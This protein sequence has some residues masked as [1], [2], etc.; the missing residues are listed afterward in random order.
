MTAEQLRLLRTAVNKRSGELTSLAR[1][2]TRIEQ[3]DRDPIANL[4]KLEK[5]LFDLEQLGNADNL[6][7]DLRDPLRQSIEA[8]R[9]GLATVRSQADRSFAVELEQL[10]APQGLHLEGH[11]PDLRAGNYRLDV[12]SAGNK[13]RIW[14]GPEQESLGEVSYSAKVVAG[15]LAKIDKE[16]CGEPL[17]ESQ[18][19]KQLDEAY[20]AVVARRS[21]ADGDRAPIVDVLGHVS[22]LKQSRKFQVDPRRENYSGYGRAQFACDLSRLKQRRLLD[23]ELHLGTATR[24]FTKNRSDFIWVPDPTG[25]TVYAQLWFASSGKGEIQ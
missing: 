25:G 21:L 24:G 5:A 12:D 9:S 18:F 10:L 1:V 11:L 23:R 7:S 3:L 17:D 2:L 16:L 14:F 4:A 13:V 8:Y 6:P 22:L 19:L 15:A 20:R